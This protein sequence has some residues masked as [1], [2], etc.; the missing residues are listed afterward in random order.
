MLV[1]WIE[2]PHIVDTLK[3]LPGTPLILWSH[4]TIEHE[5]RKQ[6]LGAFVAAGVVKQTLEDFEIPFEFV[7]GKP[8]DTRVLRVIEE[9]AVVSEAIRKLRNTRL[10]LFGYP[11]LGMYTGTVDHIALK[12][13]FGPEIVHIDQYQLVHRAAQEREGDV[14]AMRN[15]MEKNFALG[16]GVAVEDLRQSLRLYRALK[17]LASEHELDA[18]TV[19]CQY[20]MSQLYKHTP[21][22]A[23]SLLGNEL[24][25]S[26][27]GDLLTLLSQMILHLLTEQVVTYVD[28][29]EVLEDRILVGCCGF[30][31]FSLSDKP[32]RR[33]GK[34]G[35]DAFSG[36][37]NSSPLKRGRVTLARVSRDK[38]GFKLHAAS[39]SSAG[40][41]DW[42]E[43][44]CP[45]F[46]GAD[47]VM[48][49]NPGRF[50]QALVSNHY[51]LVYGDATSKLER[52]CRLM[53]VR[54]ICT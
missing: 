39:G 23:L 44:G 51:A 15:D 13:A 30:C 31:P 32:D 3:M 1:S 9:T 48:D 8:D 21:C 49:G 41:S 20:E 45:A 12:K 26:C 47:V 52:F 40:K 53:N 29:H 2:A 43:V 25:V 28:I 36:L 19:K 16:E 18:V 35:W 7:Y 34:W 11:A 54:Y 10:G 27:E 46:P 42:R 24:T 33:I 6:T 14:P 50:A 22:V 4:T 37:L 38:G 17:G 5:G